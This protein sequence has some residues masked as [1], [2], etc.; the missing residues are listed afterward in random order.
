MM[1]PEKPTELYARGWQFGTQRLLSGVAYPSDIEGGRAVA[2]LLVALMLQKPEFRADFDAAKTELRNG[3]NLG[4]VGYR[5][6]AVGN[7]DASRATIS[8]G[9][10]PR[11]RMSVGGD[12]SAT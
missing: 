10:R 11:L 12:R 7:V 6:R 8:S 3:I 1:V 9:T 5:S 2:M 4:A